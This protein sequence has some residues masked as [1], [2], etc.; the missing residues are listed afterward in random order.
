[1]PL[2]TFEGNDGSGKTT[3]IEAVA[4]VLKSK[5]IDPLIIREPGGTDAGKIIRNLILDANVKLSA[6]AT[7]LLFIADR[8]NLCEEIIFPALINN[9]VILCDRFTDSTLAYQGYGE[10][11]GD[12][13]L[14]SEINFLNTISSRVII[15]I[16]T[17]WLD[18]DPSIGLTRIKQRGEILNRIEQKPLEF[19]Q[20]VREGYQTIAKY[21]PNRI[22]R[23]E[24]DQSIEE[25]TF[26]I[27]S[28]I[29]EL[30]DYRISYET[31]VPTAPII[32]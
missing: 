32:Q 16:R 24:A 3:Q 6:T 20:R 13:K 31:G 22:V 5:G 1:M 30:I 14:I 29:L 10:G 26:R 23:I 15:P 11:K 18:I 2:I 4:K 19:H 21:N 12:L 25:I 28:D 7:L 27:V 9:R 8:A 17:F